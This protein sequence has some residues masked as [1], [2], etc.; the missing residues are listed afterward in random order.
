MRIE[1]TILNNTTQEKVYAISESTV[2]GA[3]AHL[4]AFE[5]HI[6]FCKSCGEP[7]NSDSE[8]CNDYCKN[9]ICINPF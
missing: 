1:I 6:I 5:R 7:I 3:I 2:D 8:Y 4:G 9:N